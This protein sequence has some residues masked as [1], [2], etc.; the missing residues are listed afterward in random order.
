MA[1]CSPMPADRCHVMRHRTLALAA[2]VFLSLGAWAGDV[3]PSQ[4]LQQSKRHVF[5]PRSSIQGVANYRCTR[6]FPVPFNGS[7]V[8]RGTIIPGAPIEMAYQFTRSNGEKSLVHFYTVS[9]PGPHDIADSWSVGG[10]LQQNVAGWEFVKA[11][12]VSQSVSREFWFSPSAAFTVKCM[13]KL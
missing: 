10:P 7:I 1:V 12:A 5:I 8:V 4:V 9:M 11:W 3:R 13:Y 6:P 2:A